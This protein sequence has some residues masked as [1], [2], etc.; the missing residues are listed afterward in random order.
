M[1]TE[2][3]FD[4]ELLNIVRIEAEAKFG[5]ETAEV[6]TKKIE[7]YHYD[8]DEY[9]EYEEFIEFLKN[10]ED[11]SSLSDF[12]RIVNVLWEINEDEI[13][14]GTLEFVK[15]QHQLDPSDK[16]QAILYI[17]VK[18]QTLD[19]EELLDKDLA[20]FLS[21]VYM[22]FDYLVELDDFLEG[23]LDLMRLMTYDILHNQADLF[24]PVYE[25][26]T[27]KFPSKF[28]LKFYLAEMYYYSKS[29]EES[30][31]LFD[32]VR[33]SIERYSKD[34]IRPLD[35][36]LYYYSEVVEKI[37]MIYDKFGE[38]EKVKTYVDYVINNLP[39]AYELGGGETECVDFHVN[40][41]FLRMRQNMKAG[42]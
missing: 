29:Y 31:A 41:F 14:R 2:E 27:K 38:D 26:A 39:I 17:R 36:Q 35:E 1:K 7:D 30:L 22:K 16:L 11:I 12:A 19:E 23:T 4:N 5:P 18:V 20:D 10:D 9:P 24:I 37:A 28:A 21:E 6:I 13:S 34:D 33:L 8:S 42:C 25:Q 15:E 32:E 3:L 40:S